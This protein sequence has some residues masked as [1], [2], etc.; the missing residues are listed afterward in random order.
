MAVTNML[1]SAGISSDCRNAAW[2][3]QIQE[4]ATQQQGT[5]KFTYLCH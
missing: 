3:T 4:S 5:G 2:N 1:S